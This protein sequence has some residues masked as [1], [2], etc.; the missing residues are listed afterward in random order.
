M[1]F[2][3]NLL[4]LIGV[5]ALLAVITI[6]W[7]FAG[8]DRKAPSVYWDIARQLAATGSP[9]DATVWK[10]KVEGGLSFEDVDHSIQSVAQS[11]NIRNVGTL[12][13]G[14]QVAA[15]HGK[16]WRKLK[17]YLYC[18][19]LT[20]AKM[21]EYSSAFSA[22]MPCRIA[23]AE[24]DQGELWLYTLNMDL[25]IH[26]GKPLPPGL[27]EEAEAVKAAIIDIMDKA[28]AGDF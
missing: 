14:G 12:Q 23:L 9:A 13:L 4:A 2:L 11:N 6:A 17:L 3:R 21:V 5:A 28:S 8:F 1:L 27:L 22:Y 25:M 26:G 19:P 20:A 10:R 7:A 15:I 16:P 24:D 18:S